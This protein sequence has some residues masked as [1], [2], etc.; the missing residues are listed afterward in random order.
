MPRYFFHTL[1]N[2]ELLTDTEG[3]VLLDPDQA[4]RAARAIAFDILQSDDAPKAM[5]VVVVV[6]DEEGDTVLELP[7]SD[8]IGSVGE[9]PSK[10]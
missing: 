7:V 4:W 1:V 2:D 10:H 6:T 9:T 5:S 8:V 3:A